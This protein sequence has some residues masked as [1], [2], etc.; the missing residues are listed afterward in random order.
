M[1]VCELIVGVDLKSEG[2]C[3]TLGSFLISWKDLKGDPCWRFWWS[4]WLMFGWVCNKIKLG[5][6]T[7]CGINL[8]AHIVMAAYILKEKL[9][10]MPIKQNHFKIRL[11]FHSKTRRRLSSPSKRPIYLSIFLLAF[12]MANVTLALSTSFRSFLSGFS[13]F[14]ASKYDW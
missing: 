5:V 3:S 8:N 12:E 13:D 11:I 10:L 9:E 14:A 4:T 7:T 1:S 2:V 6:Y